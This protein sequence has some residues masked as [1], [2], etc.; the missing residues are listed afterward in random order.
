MPQH[1]KD[2]VPI[3]CWIFGLYE[4]VKPKHFFYIYY[5]CIYIYTNRYGCLWEHRHTPESWSEGERIQQVIFG[6]GHGRCDD[7]VGG[8]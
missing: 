4:N 3:V 7:D 5:I 2:L 6:V 1:V 8:G